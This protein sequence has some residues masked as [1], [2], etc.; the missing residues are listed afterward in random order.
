MLTNNPCALAVHECRL[1]WPDTPIQ[2]VVSVGTGR[3]DPMDQEFPAELSSLKTKLIKVLCSAT[4]TEGELK[5]HHNTHFF[6][7]C[8]WNRKLTAGLLHLDHKTA[9]HL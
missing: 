3:Y 7:G 8:K 9:N 4:D 2:C 5:G 1:L 6:I